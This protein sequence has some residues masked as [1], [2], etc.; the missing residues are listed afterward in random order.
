MIINR[1][2]TI[3]HYLNL[4]DILARFIHADDDPLEDDRRNGAD[5][6]GSQTSEND[7]DEERRDTLPV[8]IVDPLG[9][10]GENEQQDR[11]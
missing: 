6:P 8:T 1:Q 5:N 9:H 7:R 4:H 2:Q 10:R 11:P 3:H